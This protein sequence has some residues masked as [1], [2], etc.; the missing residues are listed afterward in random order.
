MRRERER[1]RSEYFKVT[2]FKSVPEVGRHY[3]S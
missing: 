1:G 3:Y 2:A